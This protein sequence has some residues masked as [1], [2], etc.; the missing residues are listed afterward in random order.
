MNAKK[1]PGKTPDFNPKDYVPNRRQSIAE[2]ATDY[3]NLSINVNRALWR[4]VDYT[5]QS[6]IMQDIHRLQSRINELCEAK[7]FFVGLAEHA[8][9]EKRKQRLEVT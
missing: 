2:S 6:E 9:L 5:S 3:W 1:E 8:K 4:E 7:I